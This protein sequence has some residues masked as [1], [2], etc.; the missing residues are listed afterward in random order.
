M[1]ADLSKGTGEL[2]RDLPNII[3]EIER[4]VRESISVSTDF[5]DDDESYRHFLLDAAIQYENLTLRELKTVVRQVYANTRSRLGPIEDYVNRDDINEIMVNGPDALF[6]ETANGIAKA[7]EGFA[8]REALEEVIRNIASDVHREINEMNPIL[9]ARLKDGSR[10]NAV[11]RNIALDGP[12]L[13]IRKFAKE[14]ITID[15]MV[16]CGTLTSECADC[17]KDMVMCGLN[18][19]ISGGTSSGKTTFLNALSEYIPNNERAVIIEDSR[20]LNLPDLP[21]LVQMECHNANSMGRG[22]VSMAMLIRTSLRMRPDRIIVGEVRGGEVFDMLQAM[23]TGHMSLSTGH[24][25]SVKG[26]LRRLEAMYLMSAQIP[27]DSIRAQIT[28][29]IDVMVHLG[30]LRDG[31]RRIIEVKELL[32]YDNGEYTLNPLFI[33]REDMKLEATGCRLKNRFKINLLGH[34][35]A[36]RL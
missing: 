26:M 3:G 30:R 17:L 34:E 9:D 20:E 21:N 10:V 4:Q 36:D 28:E 32:G 25:N 7:D 2:R 29:G 6:Y 12:S 16:K 8:S 18:I 22:K 24:G 1:S 5:V 13:T 14:R 27:M 31:S 35:Y 23:N 19:F 11:Y 15:D 33:M